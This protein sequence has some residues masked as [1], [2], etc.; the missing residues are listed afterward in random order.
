MKCTRQPRFLENKSVKITNVWEVRLASRHWHRI[1]HFAALRRRTYS[2][3]T[4]YCV[5]RLARKCSL[6]WTPRLK[7]ANAT[8]RKDLVPA[9]STHR[10]MLCL[11]GEDEKLIRVAAMDL[12]LTVAGFIRLA[13]ELYLDALAMEKHS[14]PIVTNEA[15]TWEAIRLIEEIQIFAENTAIWPAQRLLNCFRFAFESYW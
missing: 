4:R 2:T 13:L 14:N 9:R 6:H 5:L 12:G 7:A 3:I 1:Q 15:L 10:H 11:Y 8:V